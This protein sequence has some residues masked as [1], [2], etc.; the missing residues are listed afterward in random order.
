[1]G[2]SV[3]PKAMGSGL[4][5]TASFVSYIAEIVEVGRWTMDDKGKVHGLTRV[6]PAIRLREP[7]GTP[8]ANT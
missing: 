6:R 3:C 7:M 1:M 4:P 2:R 5:Y 8:E